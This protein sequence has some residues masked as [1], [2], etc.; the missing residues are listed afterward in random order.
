M[1]VI[2]CHSVGLEAGGLGVECLD[3]VLDGLTEVEQ[4][5][6]ELNVLGEHVLARRVCRT[7]PNGL[8]E[9]VGPLQS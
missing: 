2:N 4:G 5:G 3:V 6:Q 1:S 7:L 9:V 8:Q